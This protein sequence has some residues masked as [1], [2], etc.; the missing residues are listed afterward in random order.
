MLICVFYL[1]I[2]FPFSRWVL[3]F[4]DIFFNVRNIFI[5]IMFSTT[6]YCYVVFL[7]LLSLSKLILF[8]KLKVVYF[9]LLFGF[10]YHFWVRFSV[11]Y[12]IES[13]AWWFVLLMCIASVSTQVAGLLSSLDC[14]GYFI[15]Y[16]LTIN[17]RIKGWIV[18]L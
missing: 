9:Y 5:L 4:L 11:Q 1:C 13:Q 16:Q 17:I 12:V 3:H 15:K 18:V 7:L 8:I 2:L 14:F 6:F 10:I